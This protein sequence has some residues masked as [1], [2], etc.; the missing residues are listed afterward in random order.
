MK[1]ELLARQWEAEGDTRDAD[2]LREQGRNLVLATAEY[3]AVNGPDGAY[4]AVE[5][6]ARRMGLNRPWPRV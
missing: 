3:A 2:V 4:K 5:Q 1:F 6:T